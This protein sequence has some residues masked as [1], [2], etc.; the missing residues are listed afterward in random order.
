MTRTSRL[1]AEAISN[2]TQSSGSS[3]RRRPSAALVSSHAGPMTAIS[4]SQN[5]TFSRM[6]AAKSR[7]GSSVAVSMNTRSA[8]NRA[9]SRSKSRRASGPLSPR[10]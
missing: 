8:P 10:R 9:A 2:L 7:P 4:A 3:S 5:A 6:A 1:R